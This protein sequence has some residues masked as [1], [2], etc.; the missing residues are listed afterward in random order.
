M[1]PSQAQRP[2]SLASKVGRRPMTIGLTPLIDVVFILIVFFM[3][4]SSF[5]QWRSVTLDAPA[6]GAGKSS[7]SRP[8]LV[9]VGPDTIRISGQTLTI[10]ELAAR[11]TDEIGTET[12]RIVLITPMDDVRVQ[13]IIR[14]V[15]TVSAAG[16]R[17]VSLLQASQR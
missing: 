8:L 6:I 14:V 15:D 10:G 13:K 11:I 16:A 5:D 1:S 17:N 4:A 3:L 7:D 2:P 9:D 12:D